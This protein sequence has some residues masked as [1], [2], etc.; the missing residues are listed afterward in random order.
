MTL[1]IQSMGS[2]A[3]SNDNAMAESIWASLK[4]ELVY[5]CHFSTIE[6][7]MFVF[8]WILWYKTTRLHSSLGYLP[9][10]EFEGQ[11]RAQLAA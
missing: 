10:V 4:I 3:D 8:E 5:E 6:A 2:V 9:P 1:I 7:R 11:L